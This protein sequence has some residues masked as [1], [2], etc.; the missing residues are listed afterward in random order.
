MLDQRTA[1]VAVTRHNVEHALR[2]ELL[3]DLGK[4]Q[5]RS[6]GGV[7]RLEHDGVTGCQGRSELP[8]GHVQRVVPRGNLADHADWFTANRRSV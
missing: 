5:G 1:G 3:S 4:Q 7:R 6:R 2:Q 8:G